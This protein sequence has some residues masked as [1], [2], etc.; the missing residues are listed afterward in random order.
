MKEYYI[1]SLKWT[2]PNSALYTFW[3]PNNGGYTWWIDKAGVYSQKEIDESPKYYNDGEDTMAVDKEVVD[4]Y[5]R[6]FDY[7][8]KRVKGIMSNS[9]TRL[10]FDIKKKQFKGGMSN[11]LEHELKLISETAVQE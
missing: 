5:I 9:E 6:E 4:K 3:G 1:I 8:T 10:A 7:Y 2:Y 11:I